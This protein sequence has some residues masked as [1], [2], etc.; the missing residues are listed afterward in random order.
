MPEPEH[1]TYPNPKFESTGNVN[2][3]T[4]FRTVSLLLLS[5]FKTLNRNGRVCLWLSTKK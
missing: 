2:R 5:L 1:R 4:I 3:F